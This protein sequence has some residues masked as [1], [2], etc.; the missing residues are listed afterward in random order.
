MNTGENKL[1][2]TFTLAAFLFPLPFTALKLTEGHTSTPYRMNPKG[3]N[4]LLSALPSPFHYTHEGTELTSQ[5][6]TPEK[7]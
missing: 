2:S 4:S 3:Y 5:T 7:G 1:S 6:L